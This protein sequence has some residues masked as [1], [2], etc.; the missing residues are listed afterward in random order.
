MG[1]EFKLSL[2]EQRK[3]LPPRGHISLSGETQAAIGLKDRF[4][5]VWPRSTDGEH[6]HNEFHVILPTS[7]LRIEG[8]DE[9]DFSRVNW[10][11]PG[12][13]GG[14][15]EIIVVSGPAAD[16]DNV[17]R[18]NVMDVLTTLSVSATRRCWVLRTTHRQLSTEIVAQI[19]QTK[20]KVRTREPNFSLGNPA[21]DEPG[22]RAFLGLARDN[23]PIG[24]IEASF[25]SGATA[26]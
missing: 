22:T 16:H 9:D 5:H 15:V 3:S 1:Q 26:L 24:W 6:L 8:Q 17:L 2:H 18:A 13:A 11:P 10:L 12:P 23:Q 25:T 21:L 7:E 20:E 14:A 19:A 4:L